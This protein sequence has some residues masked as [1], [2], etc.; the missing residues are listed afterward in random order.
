[1]N[2]YGKINLKLPFF[3]LQTLK[4]DSITFDLK[5]NSIFNLIYSKLKSSFEK[6]DKNL[7]IDVKGK[8]TDKKSFTLQKKHYQEYIDIVQVEVFKEHTISEAEYFRTL[9]YKYATLPLFEREKILYDKNFQLLEG[10]IANNQRIIIQTK[11]R[12][13]KLEPYFIKQSEEFSYVFGYCFTKEEY[14]VF[15][16]SNIDN[17]STVNEKIEY[18]NEE[19]IFNIYKNFDPF[20]SYGKEVKVRFTPYG[21]IKY[22]TIISNR[23]KLLSQQDN[24]YVFECS[25]KKAQVYFPQFFT[26][27]EIL[28]PE[29][30]RQWYRNKLEEA[31]EYYKG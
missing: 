2:E 10:S 5:E 3:I 30:L 25:E 8:Y 19:E 23:P 17:I 26:E 14:R 28:E 22:N 18:K 6:S 24:I 9:F 1:M 20:L 7:K 27:V 4:N 11:N 21:K 13:R 31:L 29:S 15:R 16:I 12:T